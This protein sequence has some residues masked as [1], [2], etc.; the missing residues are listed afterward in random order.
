MT[1]GV[2]TRATLCQCVSVYVT[3]KKGRVEEEE[4]GCYVLDLHFS[5]P[6]FAFS[7]PPAMSS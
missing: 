5:L 7:F 4:G 2:I 3:I 6:R 1:A